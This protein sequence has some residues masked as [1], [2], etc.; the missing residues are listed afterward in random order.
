MDFNRIIMA[1][2]AFGAVLGGLDW[3]AGNRLGLG[4]K[5]EDGFLC[6]GPTAFSMVGILCLAPPAAKLLGPAVAPLFRAIGA[7]P[8]MFAGIL[9]IDMGGYSLAVELAEDA[10]LGLFSGLIVSSM[11]GAAIVFLIPLGLGM[12]EKKDR[13][14]FAQGLLVGLIP[15]P[16]GAFIGGL[17]MGLEPGTVLVNLVPCIGIGLVMVL[18]IRFFPKKAIRLFL[19]F[20]RMIQVITVGGLTAAAVEYMTGICLIPGMP[21]IMEG[22]AVAGS[23]AVVL[24]GSLPLMEALLRVFNR[25]FQAAGRRAG[26]DSASVAGILFCS[27][28]V[29]PVLQAMK[30]MCPRG[31]VVVTAV[32][33][34]LISV[35]AAHLG[36]T[37]Q[38]APAMLAPVLASKLVSGLLALLLALGLTRNMEKCGQ[39]HE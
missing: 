17:M 13:E 39:I 25:L 28:S 12:I 1:A 29:L 19:F 8:A 7:D 38:A 21:P 5:F 34:S 22:M 3:M 32:S 31:K 11:L 23:I 16:A 4:K 30:E 27:V 37:V 6:L 26:L 14:Y 24:L 9:A 20:G 33:V 35:F 15:I 2:M 18:G 10:G 36:F